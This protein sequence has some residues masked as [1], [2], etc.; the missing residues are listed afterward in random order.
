MI[1]KLA[2]DAPDSLVPDIGPMGA[3]A[4]GHAP[5]IAEIYEKDKQ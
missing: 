3:A 4:P 2:G 5:R 1:L